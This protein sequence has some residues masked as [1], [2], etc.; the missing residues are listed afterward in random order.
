MCKVRWMYMARLGGS[1]SIQN[2]FCNEI[3]QQSYNLHYPLCFSGS[4][5]VNGW[6]FLLPSCGTNLGDLEWV[7]GLLFSHLF[8]RFL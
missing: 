7:T 2:N 5:G 8:A 4:N 3:L 6:V 1:T